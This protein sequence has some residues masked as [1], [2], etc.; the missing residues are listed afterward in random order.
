MDGGDCGGKKEREE[1]GWSWNLYSVWSHRHIPMTK[2]EIN[3]QNRRPIQVGPFTKA[4][5]L[6]LHMDGGIS[7]FLNAMKELSEIPTQSGS[8]RR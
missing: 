8:K 5:V 4:D 7:C 3:K 6:R 2:A 1:S